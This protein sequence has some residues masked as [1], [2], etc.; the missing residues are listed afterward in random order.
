MKRILVTGGGGYVGSLL[1][2]AL[3]KEGYTVR[4]LDTFW[5]GQEVIPGGTDIVVGDL[6][7]PETVSESLKDCDA[8]IHLACIS[9]DPSFELNPEL[10]KSINYDCFPHLVRAS[11]EN[12][13]ERFIYASS[14]SVYGVKSEPNVTEDLSLEPLTD[15]SK[16]KALCEDYL[17]QSDTKDMEWVTIRPATVCGY[18][19][20]LRLDLTVNILTAHA[21]FNKAMTVFG[22]G[23]LRPNINIKDMVS[24]Y[25]LLLKAPKELIH[26]DVFNV[27][28]ENHSV[29]SIAEMIRDIVGNDV[30]L[31]STESSDNRSYHISS[32]KIK[33]RLGFEP[34]FTIADAV[35]D[36]V[37]AFKDG[38][39]SNPKDPKYTNIKRLQEIL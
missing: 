11:V 19:P 6:R 28:Y 14:S 26:R 1:V 38:K 21:Y 5:F 36:L 29:L 39:V 12:G 13:V 34:E 32:K 31:T 16:Y 2:P 8:V 7:D 24:A 20:R 22:G 25:L 3:L 15:Y 17:K 9:N 10:G 30:S 23:Q 33:D 35:T 4:V 18:A 27:G 37:S